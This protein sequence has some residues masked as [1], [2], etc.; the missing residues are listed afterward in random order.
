MKLE[1]PIL[2]L[3]LLVAVAA[4]ALPEMELADVPWALTLYGGESVLA[5]FATFLD[6][7]AAVKDR[8]RFSELG[9]H[10]LE[11]LGGFPG[12]YV[13]QNVFRHK[14]VKRSY[15]VVFWLIVLVH[16]AG[17]AWYLSIP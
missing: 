10:L 12:A 2:V 4:F 6:K 5:G 8:R 13:A 15:K 7:R 14:T 17:W 11:L 16:I 1:K 3:G 9:L